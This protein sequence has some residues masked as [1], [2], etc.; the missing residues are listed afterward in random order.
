MKY[1]I[2]PY[3]ADQALALIEHLHELIDLLHDAYQQDFIEQ[4]GV[5]PIPLEH[6]IELFDDPLDF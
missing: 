4:S 6:Q 5:Y 3:D 2:L 1:A